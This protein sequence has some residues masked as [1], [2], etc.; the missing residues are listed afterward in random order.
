MSQVWPPVPVDTG[1]VD[2]SGCLLSGWSGTLYGRKSGDAIS[3]QGVVTGP[4]VPSSATAPDIASG[5]AS[6]FRPSIRN[7]FGVLYTGAYLGHFFVRT[8][9]TAGISNRSG[10][11]FA[12]GA[13]IQL[14]V[15]FLD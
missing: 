1:W 6:A 9:G 8:D 5:I 11:T 12:A 10:A 7:A 15:T 2:L 13:S 3:V 4:A 14:S